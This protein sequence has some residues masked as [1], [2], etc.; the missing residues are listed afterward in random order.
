MCLVLKSECGKVHFH[1]N[2]HKNS[3]IF[4]K[5]NKKCIF[6]ILTIS[7][8]KQTKKKKGLPPKLSAKNSLQTL[9]VSTDLDV[10]AGSA[11]DF[12][13]NGP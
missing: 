13:W 4:L 3:I 12:W 6:C 1:H 9:R 2:F 11:G 10:V 7:L 5:K 8:Q